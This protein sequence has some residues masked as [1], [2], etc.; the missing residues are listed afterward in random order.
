M[1]GTT[2]LGTTVSF[3]DGGTAYS[4][5]QDVSFSAGSVELLDVTALGDTTRVKLA[6]HVDL[7]TVSVTLNYNKTDYS[8][9]LALADGGTETITVTFSDGSTWSGDGVIDQPAFN[10]AGGSAV[11][12][13]V[14]V[15]QLSAWAFDD[16]S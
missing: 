5:V 11:S 14:N 12:M 13:S 4:D 2:P 7:G 8:A 9:I 1:A 6:G 16:G 3:T 10:I 15:Q